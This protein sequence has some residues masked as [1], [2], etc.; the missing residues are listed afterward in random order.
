MTDAPGAKGWP[1][2]LWLLVVVLVVAAGGAWYSTQRR[3][4]E[5]AEHVA[6]GGGR[7][8]LFDFGMGVC[9]QCKRMKPV[10]ERAARELGACLDVRVL[11][12]RD[13]ANGQLAERYRMHAIPFILLVDGG[14]KELWRHEGFVAFSGISQAVAKHLG[15]APGGSCGRNQ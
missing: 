15:F 4:T 14:G 5:V 10:M 12:I 7:P 1:A 3:S 6:I 9:A 13:E 2:R 8:Q 11:D